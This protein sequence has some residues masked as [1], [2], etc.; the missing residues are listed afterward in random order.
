MQIGEYGSE[1]EVPPPDSVIEDIMPI[2]ANVEDDWYLWDILP[3]V[4]KTYHMVCVVTS[5]PYK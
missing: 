1:E 5:Q 2:Q 4:S 3:P